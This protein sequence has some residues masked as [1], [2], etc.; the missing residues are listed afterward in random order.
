MTDLG[1]KPTF[2]VTSFLSLCSRCRGCSGP[3]HTPRERKLGSKHINQY[4]C[5]VRAQAVDAGLSG[6]ATG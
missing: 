1:S 2:K 3:G 6:M 4:K 5:Q